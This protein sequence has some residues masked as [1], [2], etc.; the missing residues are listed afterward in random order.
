VSSPLLNIHS[1]DPWGLG[2]ACYGSREKSRIKLYHFN[3]AIKTREEKEEKSIYS[4][5]ACYVL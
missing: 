3:D 4:D 2:V 5:S 1:T